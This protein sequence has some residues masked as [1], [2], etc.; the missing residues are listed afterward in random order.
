MCV[1]LALVII[2]T[3]VRRNGTPVG[4]ILMLSYKNHALDEFLCDVLKF[5][6]HLH[7]GQLIRL[8][9][10]SNPELYPYAERNTSDEREAERDVQR[11][12]YIQRAGRAM[13]RALLLLARCPERHTASAVVILKAMEIL[14]CCADGY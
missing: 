14:A 12:V 4:P 8:G 13:A 5:S 1:I 10:I 6:P 2:R 7:Q 9:V 11:R 3:M